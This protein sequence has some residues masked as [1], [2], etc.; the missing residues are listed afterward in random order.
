[1]KFKDTILRTLI[2]ALRPRT[3][4]EIIVRELREAHRE[5]LEAESAVEYAQS[6]VACNE[7]RIKRL[8]YRL[9]EH[10]KENSYE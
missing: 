10:T 4:A 2:N 1:M 7:T 5:K 3:I 9:V 6:I 8:Q